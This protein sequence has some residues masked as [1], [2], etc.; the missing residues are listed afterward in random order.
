LQYLHWSRA[1]ERSTNG[2]GIKSVGHFNY[3]TVKK[4][5]DLWYL[6]HANSTDL[7]QLVRLNFSLSMYLDR[8]LGLRLM[9]SEIN[10][11]LT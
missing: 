8:N 3:F 9:L 10:Y 6:F 11:F 5:S 2:V 7:S 4:E 1:S